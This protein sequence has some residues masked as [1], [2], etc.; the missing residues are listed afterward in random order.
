VGELLAARAVARHALAEKF[1]SNVAVI[2][3]DCAPGCGVGAS[4]YAASVCESSLIHA[5]GECD[6]A[7]CTVELTRHG[8]RQLSMLFDVLAVSEPMAHVR[9]AGVPMF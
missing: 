7:P 3:S 1:A 4:N 9:H 2:E 6:C 8:L 5:V